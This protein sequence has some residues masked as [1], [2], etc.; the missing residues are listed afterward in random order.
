MHHLHRT[1]SISHSTGTTA[2]ARSHRRTL[3]T[4][5]RT[6]G[7][8]IR[9]PRASI[10]Y[11]LPSNFT[12]SQAQPTT[13]LSRPPTANFTPTAHRQPPRN[14]LPY[15]FSL[16]FIQAHVPDEPE[17]SKP[18]RWDT[19]PIQ[20]PQRLLPLSQILPSEEEELEALTCK[21]VNKR[22]P[23]GYWAGRFGSLID[24]MCAERP[25]DWEK[26]R[27]RRAFLILEGYAIGGGRE[28][29]LVCS[30]SLYP[31][32]PFPSLWLV[33]REVWLTVVQEFKSQYEA[34]AGKEVRV[35]GE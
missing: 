15:S 25:G 2:P 10:P 26:E 21:Y 7:S 8:T 12:C 5:V 23:M 29:L 32:E 3:S 11:Q 35:V 28:S 16:P 27:A 17:P 34:I 19:P 9:P 22:M 31:F 4:S 33:S 30:H 18:S 1:P 24:R 13:P 20:P 6:T 14:S